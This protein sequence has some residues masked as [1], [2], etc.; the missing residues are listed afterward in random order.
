MNDFQGS[1][2]DGEC[3]YSSIIYAD[4]FWQISQWKALC[5]FRVKR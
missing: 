4:D 3:T 1:C 2:R 5:P